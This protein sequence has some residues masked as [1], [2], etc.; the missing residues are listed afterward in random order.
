[1]GNLLDEESLFALHCLI[2]CD[3]QVIKTLCRHWEEKKSTKCTNSLNSHRHRQNAP[4]W[5]SKRKGLVGHLAPMQQTRIKPPSPP[6][7]IYKKKK[8]RTNKQQQEKHC[9]PQRSCM[10]CWRSFREPQILMC[11]REGV[12]RWI[13]CSQLPT[14]ESGTTIRCGPSTFMALR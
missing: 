4:A 6:K 9:N 8:T 14:V 13:S 2:G 3:V 1:M 12:K 10:A 5:T 7:K 11:V